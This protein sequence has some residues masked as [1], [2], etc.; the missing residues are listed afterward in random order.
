MRQR[1]IWD[2]TRICTT[3]YD[4]PFKFP[5]RD[6]FTRSNESSRV[7]HLLEENRPVKTG[8]QKT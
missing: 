1:N 6:N 2:I 4:D 5:I 8:A 7:I 3:P